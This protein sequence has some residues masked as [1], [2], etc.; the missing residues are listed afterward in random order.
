MV[1]LRKTLVAQKH[2]KTNF[3]P[4]KD[5]IFLPLSGCLGTPLPLSQSLYGR[6]GGHALTSESKLLGSIGYQI[7]FAPL[8]SA[9]LGRK[10]APLLMLRYS[11]NFPPAPSQ[12]LPA[13]W[14]VEVWRFFLLSI[15][16]M[17]Q[18]YR[19]WAVDYDRWSLVIIT[20]ASIT[21]RFQWSL[22][23]LLVDYLS[24]SRGLPYIYAIMV[25]ICYVFFAIFY[26]NSQSKEFGT[27][28]LLLRVVSGSHSTL[29]ANTKCS[30]GL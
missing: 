11:G 15:Q 18:I 24:I 28:L 9:A 4:R 13:S 7:C 23:R 8:R 25:C 27:T 21:R 5:G 30:S 16:K 1:P 3:S 10:E 19:L 6:G 17:T 12:F 20:M 2:R 29:S 14:E 26:Q 22:I